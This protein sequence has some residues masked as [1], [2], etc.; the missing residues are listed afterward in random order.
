LAV[1]LARIEHE[2]LFLI[3]LDE[4]G[5]WFTRRE[6]EIL[7]LIAAAGSNQ[8]VADHLGISV[9][10]VRAPPVDLPQDRRHQSGG[11]SPLCAEPVAAGRSR[12]RTGRLT[13]LR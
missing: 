2:Q 6:S 7:A 4:H 10:T 9:R 3:P 13:A 12:S 8:Q 1:L 11:R 5:Q